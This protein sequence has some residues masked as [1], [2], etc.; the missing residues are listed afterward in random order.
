MSET[1]PRTPNGDDHLGK[2]VDDDAV[3]ADRVDGDAV[4]ANRAED[5][6]VDDRTAATEAYTPVAAR[7]PTGTVST[8]GRTREPVAVPREDVTA[9]REVVGRQADEYAGIKWGS[10]FFGWLSA[11]GMT[12]L[13]V[14]ILSAIGAGVDLSANNG[15]ANSAAQA[16]NDNAATVGIVGA[17]ALAV[18][19]FVSYFC[20]GYV[21]GRMARFAGIRQGF[22]VW[23]WAIIFAII[24]AIIAAIAGSKYDVL[25]Q[26]NSFPRIPVSEGTL[27]TGG[28]I[29]AIVVAVLSLVGALLGGLAGMRYHRAV[30]RAGFV[31]PVEEG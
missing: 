1:Y 4:N 22:A 14:A 17:I 24:G 18:I 29:T 26:L 15:D 12:V 6:G 30:D 20:G 16:A 27:T 8:D 10:A 28:I 7:T 31:A 5:D 2:H 13:L 25:G 23:I 11:M 3:N 19:L 9:R 21:A